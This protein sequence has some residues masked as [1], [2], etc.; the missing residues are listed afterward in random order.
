M[1]EQQI[2]E[3][4]KNAFLKGA[5]TEDARADMRKARQEFAE[6]HCDID[7]VTT[8][9]GYYLVCD[10]DEDGITSGRNESHGWNGSVFYDKDYPTIKDTFDLFQEVLK[11]GLERFAIVWATDIRVFETHREKFDGIPAEPTGEGS[12]TTIL[13]HNK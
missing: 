6:G 5:T 12:D 7:L 8:A 2:K 9:G 4:F 13:I 3:Q 10:L 11:S 1:N